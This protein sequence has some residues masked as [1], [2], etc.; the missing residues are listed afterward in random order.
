VVAVAALAAVG[1][2]CGGGGGLG[3]VTVEQEVEFG[4]QA[5]EQI[6]SD[7]EGG[8]Q[9]CVEC[10]GLTLSSGESLSA[11]VEQLGQELGAVGN[12]DR[13]D[14]RFQIPQWHFTVLQSDEINAFALPGGY[15]YVTTGL[16]AMVRNKAE[17]AGIVGHEVAHVTKY[18]GVERLE[19]FMIAQGLTALL[20]G[21]ENEL[22]QQIAAFLTQ[23]K[24]LVSS[25][26]D[27]LEADRHGVDYAYRTQW[28]PL[29]MNNFFEDIRALYGEP[30]QNPLSDVL[31]SHPPPSERIEQVNA[32]AAALGITRDTP[33]LRIDDDRVPYAEVQAAVEPFVPA[34]AALFARNRI[35]ER[36]RP[37][38]HACTFDPRTRRLIHVHPPPGRAGPGGGPSP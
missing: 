7:G 6:T 13:G 15:I 29:E 8:Y 32:E 4:R 9:I 16:L 2:G 17:L 37:F 11:Y 12:P 35:P 23:V 38:V 18:H 25:Q 33:G 31:A 28:N 27:E 10:Q 26:D 5:H 20:F 3:L 22:A 1:A 14:P 34:T 36:L 30:A 24:F 19:Q 21:D